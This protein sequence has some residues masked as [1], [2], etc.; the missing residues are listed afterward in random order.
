MNS[1][2]RALKELAR[3][4]RAFCLLAAAQA[5][6]IAL[7]LFLQGLIGGIYD[8]TSGALSTQRAQLVVYGADSA[9]DL[10]ASRITSATAAR[11]SGVSGTKQVRGFGAVLAG[12]VDPG[13]SAP[14]SMMGMGSSSGS[15][16]VAVI[17]YQASANGIPAP[18]PAGEAWAD[19]RLAASGV[20][21]GDVLRVGPGMQPVRVI[22]WVSHT[23]L[24]L[25]AGLWVSPPTWR[26]VLT[27]A[28]P[29]SAL[30]SG[31]FQVLLVTARPGVAQAALAA[32]IDRATGGATRTLTLGQA[33]GALPG[34]SAMRAT[35]DGVIAV[36]LVIAAVIMALFFALAVIERRGA[37]ALLKA[38]GLRG[39]S[40]ASDVVIQA[41]VLAAA[42]FAVTALLAL[43]M[44]PMAPTLPFDL[45]TAALAVSALLVGVAAAAGTL[46]AIRASRRIDPILALSDPL[47]A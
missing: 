22:G 14:A 19:R 9:S 31:E 8:Q 10:L 7:I 35:F 25:Q 36:T 42:A 20:Q 4:K 37:I 23:S 13:R 1:W 44:A 15:L 33:I 2:E 3:R 17:G 21:I 46:G 18:P 27:S 11:V 38:A 30:R 29:A 16:S 26:Q 32:D 6:L 24:L 34:L 39:R 41:L 28:R 5:V 12:A 47:T 43:G 40:L 45:S